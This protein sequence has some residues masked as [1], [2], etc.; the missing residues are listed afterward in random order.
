MVIASDDVTPSCDVTQVV[1]RPRDELTRHW[2]AAVVKSSDYSDY[3]T[4]HTLG[5]GGQSRI[6][7]ATWRQIFF[8]IF[9]YHGLRFRL[10]SYSFIYYFGVM[11]R[12]NDVKSRRPRCFPGAASALPAASAVDGVA[13]KNK[14]CVHHIPDTRSRGTEVNVIRRAITL[15]GARVTGAAPCSDW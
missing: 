13:Q 6:L 1:R 15:R 5:R 12:V 3:A 9:F 10:T 8:S 4:L 2:S 7:E 11:K 14:A